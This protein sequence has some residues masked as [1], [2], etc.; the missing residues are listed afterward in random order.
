M[1]KIKI[2]PREEPKLTWE[3]MISSPGYYANQNYRVLISCT[4]KDNNKILILDNQGNICSVCPRTNDWVKKS[5]SFKYRL[6]ENGWEIEAGTKF[7]N[8]LIVNKID[9]LDYNTVVEFDRSGSPVLAQVVFAEHRPNNKGLVSLHDGH[10]TWINSGCNW[11]PFKVL[12]T[13]IV[14]KE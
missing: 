11:G 12:G 8:G 9:S 4:S 10:E 13:L 7:F 6:E 5:N 1:Y 14:E 3:E 2:K